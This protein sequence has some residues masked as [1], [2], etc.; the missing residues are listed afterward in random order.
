MFS[1]VCHQITIHSK[2]I[3]H[4][5]VISS[6]SGQHFCCYGPCLSNKK[7][8]AVD[9][10]ITTSFKRTVVVAD[11]W[12]HFMKFLPGRFNLMA[13]FVFKQPPVW[14]N[15]NTKIAKLVQFGSQKF[16]CVIAQWVMEEFHQ[17]SSYTDFGSS[18]RKC[19]M[20][21]HL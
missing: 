5:I 3:Y 2:P 21:V 11:N 10:H 1:Q 20:L 13:F 8:Y 14:P 17:C 6:Q 18:L 19:F 12:Q 7:H 4:G 15:C 16:V 9:I